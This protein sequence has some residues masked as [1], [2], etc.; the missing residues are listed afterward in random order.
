MKS[1]MKIY[2]KY[3]ATV[4]LLILA[5]V[6]LQLSILGVITAKLY[7]GGNEHGKYS[8]RQAYDMLLFSNGVVDAQQREAV[9]YLEEMQVSFG[10]LLDQAGRPVWT[11][12][13]PEN[14]NHAYTS[15]EIASFTR[16]YLD[17]YPVSVWGGD[18]GLLV[19]GYPRGSVWHYYIHQDMRDLQG[20]MTFFS[21]SF[22]LT[23]LAA[24]VILLAAGYRYY[25]KMRGM[26]DAIG[27]LASGGS[28]HLPE[29]GTMEEIAIALNRTSD[30]LSKQ[31]SQLERRDEA[32][33]EWI[34]GVSHD[35]RT[36][37]SLIMG[38]ADMIES[39]PGEEAEVRKRAALIRS[40]SIRIR[41]L[42]EDLNLTSKLEYHMQPL[43]LKMIFPASILRKVAADLINTIERPQD[44]PFSI[45]ISPE[46]ERF[47]MAGD[48]RL[49]SRA[50]HNILGNS[51]RHN[52]AG[53][54]FG[55]Q[56]SMEKGRIKIIFYDSGNG[57]PPEV[58]HFLN[59]GDMAEGKIHVMGLRIVRQI[60]KAH[61][62]E[63]HANA[64]GRGISIEF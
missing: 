42:I 20:I 5:F 47:T 25:R 4:I 26:T 21:L 34:S 13:L 58:C 3:I 57:I 22:V 50:F 28:V 38:Y 40:Q 8:V 37:L 31:R 41:D 55:I 36:P 52:K 61:G 56:A 17:D 49:L 43:R 15:T 27:Q 16:W 35:I 53:C 48:E 45:E 2:I 54:D 32:R 7:G 9:A 6:I 24:L 30:R 39:R 18:K 11:Y 60:I 29:S 14:L 46:V 12:K 10:M 33:T 19:I 63:L 23:I 59:E 1:L 51:I 62:G 44:Y 64:D